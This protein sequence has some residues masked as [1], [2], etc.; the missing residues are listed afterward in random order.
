M[1]ERRLCV[2]SELLRLDDRQRDALLVL[3]RPNGR[4][5]AN[6]EEEEDEEEEEKAVVF[7]Q[8]EDETKGNNMPAIQLSCH[9]LDGLS[10]LVRL[11]SGV[12]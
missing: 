6:N 10:S 5:H 3:A 11:Q 2:V 9:G 1:M 7:Q 8:T 4:T 12:A